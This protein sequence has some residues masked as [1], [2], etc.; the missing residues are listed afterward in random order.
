[1]SA[2]TSDSAPLGSFLELYRAL[3]DIVFLE[4]NQQE[5]EKKQNRLERARRL[6]KEELKKSKKTQ[7]KA[8]TLTLR[9]QSSYL[10]DEKTKKEWNREEWEKEWKRQKEKDL[11]RQKEEWKGQEEEW[12]RQWKKQEEEK[13]KKYEEDLQRQEE[14]WKR[15]QEERKRQDT[16]YM[17]KVQRL[18]TQKKQL[19]EQEMIKDY[20]K[21][22]FIY[23]NR[24]LNDKLKNNLPK[25]NKE[26]IEQIK[27]DIIIGLKKGRMFEENEIKD[28]LG[29][30]KQL[31]TFFHQ[32]QKEINFQNELYLTIQQIFLNRKIN[33][34]YVEQFKKESTNADE[35][36]QNKIKLIIIDYFKK[37]KYPSPELHTTVV[38]ILQSNPNLLSFYTE[39]REKALAT[40][41]P[42]ATSDL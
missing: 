26:T 11:Q 10:T 18:E 4:E 28:L 30:N 19:K 27:D 16:E 34:K 23:L 40:S 14:D 24:S 38:D 37:K 22:Y 9:T 13:R 21:N 12:K 35:E 3:C 6:L 29:N 33:N 15:Q 32:K 36:T 5:I 1:M 8:P 7:F 39:E 20:S 25:A 17:Q 42:L 31:E 2:S 41:P